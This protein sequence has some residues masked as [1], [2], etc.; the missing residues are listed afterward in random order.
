MKQIARLAVLGA[1]FVAAVPFASAATLVSGKINTQGAALFTYPPETFTVSSTGAATLDL[2]TPGVTSGFTSGPPNSVTGPPSTG[3]LIA[4]YPSATVTD[5]SFSTA[6]IST[7]TPTLIL[8]VANGTDTLSFFATSTGPFIPTSLPATEGSL[9][10]F[11][12]LSDVGPTFATTQ[13]VELDIAANGIG[14]NFTEDL[15]V[16]APTPEPSSLMLLGTGLVSA[17]GMMFRRRKIVA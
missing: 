17:G 3:N 7:A 13:G 2:V 12:Y 11:G 9:V 8:S 5:Y 10:L 4:F 6:T 16:S 1:A 14:N 15:T